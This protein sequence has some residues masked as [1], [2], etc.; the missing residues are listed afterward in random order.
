MY[1]TAAKGNGQT[2]AVGRDREG[3][4]AGASGLGSAVVALAVTGGESSA[5]GT[6]D[7]EAAVAQFGGCLPG[8]LVGD[9]ELG[10]KVTFSGQC[11][12]AVWAKW[13]DMIRG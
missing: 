10:S 5:S 9:A 2:C 11:A 12:S 7:D 1:G 3:C 4:G 13:I 8:C 6:G